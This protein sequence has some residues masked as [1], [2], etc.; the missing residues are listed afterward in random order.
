M[1]TD[2]ERLSAIVALADKHDFAIRGADGRLTHAP[3]CL[4]PLQMQA[5]DYY[6]M[7]RVMP[8]FS[9]LIDRV[10]RD[11]D[12]VALHLD[13]VDPF[14]TRLVRILRAVYMNDGSASP[15]SSHSLAHDFTPDEEAAFSR[16]EA[17]VKAFTAQRTMLGVFRSD[18]MWMPA[19]A[20]APLSAAARIVG[21]P[22][23]RGWKQVEIN[24]ISCSFPA[25]ST[26]VGRVQRALAHNADSA[27]TG[28]AAVVVESNSE[29]EVIGAMAR[30][31]R[32]WVGGAGAFDQAQASTAAPTWIVAG[33]EPAA[34]DAWRVP[35]PGS[36]VTVFL[37]QDGER[38]VGDQRLLAEGL[39]SHHNVL[40]VRKSLTQLVSDMALVAFPGAS[41]PHAVVRCRRAEFDQSAL[42][43]DAA[44]AAAAFADGAGEYSYFY[45]SL[46]YLR[47]LY[48]VADFKS[49]LAWEARGLYEASS[50]I[51]CPSLPYHLCT[52]KRIQQLLCDAATL[53]RFVST[54]AE[55][56]V[57]HSFM[58]GHF[59]MLPEVPK[60]GDGALESPEAIEAR[61]VDARDHPE[62]WVVKSLREGYGFIYIDLEMTRRLVALTAAPGTAVAKD[63]A[64][65]IPRTDATP[66]NSDVFF[67]TAA[68]QETFRREHLVV[69]RI[70]A[71]RRG[72][73]IARDGKISAYADLESEVG[74]Y[75]V[76]LSDGAYVFL[77]DVAGYLIRTKSGA[78][79]G[80][81]VMSGVASL[82]TIAIL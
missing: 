50:A 49:A 19:A 3:L 39:T 40:V 21:V 61:V 6:T 69:E 36:A 57:L 37:V 27:A 8:L 58:V 79:L 30:A 55:A 77:N 52:W 78:T 43:K 2:A 4:T 41:T 47:S 28:G 46:F 29:S 75:G 5:H 24:T 14:V 72:G 25:L 80:G 10:A 38:N 1:A 31:H 23:N 66:A 65:I 18:Y 63:A 16:L 56:A 12:F 71:P 33:A 73:E 67:P 60:P 68:A 82:D 70:R 59:Q 9:A 76:V 32:H 7:E 26:R 42:K 48:D 35:A 44:A 15:A 54:D 74:T 34:A 53:R 51:K 81:G 17:K 64:T 62:R 20:S 13:G 45:V 11:Y 22:V